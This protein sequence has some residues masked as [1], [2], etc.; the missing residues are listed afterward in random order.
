MYPT[1]YG[2]VI[3]FGTGTMS[4]EPTWSVFTAMDTVYTN[5]MHKENKHEDNNS[6]THTHTHT[7]THTYTY[8]HIVH[9]LNGGP[10][11]NK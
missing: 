8:T 10:L 11:H 9:G 1:M 5:I 2:Y 6:T 7:H 3:H 4:T